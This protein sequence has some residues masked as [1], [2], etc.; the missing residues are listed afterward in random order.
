MSFF[1]VFFSV[2]EKRTDKKCFFKI[3]SFFFSPQVRD[4]LDE[5]QRRVRRDLLHQTPIQ[6]RDAAVSGA[7]EVAVV[8][9]FFC[10]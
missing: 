7:E 8:V 2:R 1:R 9:E 6:N 10:V 5:R 3:S 4:V